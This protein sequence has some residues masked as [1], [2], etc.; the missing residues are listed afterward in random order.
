MFAENTHSTS[1]GAPDDRSCFCTASM[2]VE[3]ANELLRK[4]CGA[5]SYSQGKKDPSQPADL[6]LLN[7]RQTKFFSASRIPDCASN[8]ISAS[9]MVGR[10]VRE[11]G[12]IYVP[13]AKLFP[14]WQCKL[15]PPSQTFPRPAPMSEAGV[16]LGAQSGCDGGRKT[17]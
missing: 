8:G 2:S 1:C 15:I 10:N 17:V 3:C 5:A 11:G 13:P 6:V 7:R 16:P 12:L 9:L 4:A 14:Q